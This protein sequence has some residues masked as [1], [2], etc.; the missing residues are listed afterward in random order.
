MKLLIE[1]LSLFS[2]CTG[3][4]RATKQLIHDL[5]AQPDIET[6]QLLY[7]VFPCSRNWSK[8]KTIE[9]STLPRV[10]IRRI[11]FPL[12]WMLF[13]WN[14]FRTPALEFL[15]GEFDLLH[16]PA[17][18]LPATRTKPSVF[19]IHDL[20]L[21]QHPE[22]YP[23]HTRLYR[24]QIECGL[25]RAQAIVVPSHA[26]K[27]QITAIDS[28]WE[29]KIHVVYHR[30]KRVKHIERLSK[31]QSQIFCFGVSFPYLLW[32]GEINPRK[33]IPYL[34]HLL[35]GLRQRGHRDL[36]LVLAGGSGYRSREIVEKGK[37]S[38]LRML[39]WNQPGS[40][41][42][43]DVIILGTVTDTR[44][45][46]LYRGADVFVFPSWDEGFGYPILEAMGHG[47]PV[48]CSNR[49]SLPEIGADAV[50]VFDPHRQSDEAVDLVDRLLRSPETYKEVQM[51]G[52]RRANEFSERRGEDQILQIYKSTIHPPA[53]P[54]RVHS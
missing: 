19:T 31:Q 26:V 25:R 35:A 37:S 45:S 48:V 6:I 5:H 1:S 14:R 39:E 9:E 17:H 32:V 18:I 20:S 11:P 30:V 29:Q 33:N 44:L 38:G 47:V 13:C 16:G 51:K 40:L 42:K 21:L 7:T 3:I 8:C 34:F 22:W 46:D 41:D 4:G 28:L 52:I 50:L 43:V 24:E 2:P 49:G 54:L 12:G 23:P 10:S 15:C 27:R 36:K 53:G